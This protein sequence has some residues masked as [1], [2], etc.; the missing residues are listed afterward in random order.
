VPTDRLQI[1]SAM[2]V[3][4]PAFPILLKSISP[5]MNYPDGLA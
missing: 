4:S 3:R 2:Q 5:D 1:R